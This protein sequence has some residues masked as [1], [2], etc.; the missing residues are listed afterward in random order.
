MSCFS[1]WPQIAISD[2]S[3]EEAIEAA[4]HYGSDDVSE[5][6]LGQNVL[7]QTPGVLAGA[8]DLFGH[9]HDHP[10]LVARGAPLA[11][12]DDALSVFPA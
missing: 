6:V 2:Q 4:R 5:E 12:L 11:G 10:R 1:K 7:G 8:S 3:M 9:A